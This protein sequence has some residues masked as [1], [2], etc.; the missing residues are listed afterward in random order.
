MGRDVALM[1]NVD[2]LASW[3]IT[4]EAALMRFC[5][6][7]FRRTSFFDLVVDVPFFEV[8]VT[9]AGTFD[10]DDFF[11]DADAELALEE[12]EE[13]DEDDEEEEEELILEC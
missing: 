10:A 7:S 1:Y 13:E 4:L 3:L 12:P 6:A 9:T 8:A 11:E 2:D 5:S